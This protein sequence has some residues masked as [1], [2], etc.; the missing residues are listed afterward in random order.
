MCNLKCS[1]ERGFTLLEVMVALVI[2]ATLSL[3]LFSALQHITRTS[4]ALSE[5][6]LATWIADNRLNELRTGIRPTDSHPSQE[7]IHFGGREWWLFC[8]IK[9]TTFPNL[10]QVQ[11][12]VAA[13]AN[14]QRARQYSRAQLNAL[15][16]VRP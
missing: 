2:F 1:T 6:T 11:V 15:I 3:A 5:R 13:E 10:L 14:L 7:R 4:S 12:A 8:T 9:P 16:E